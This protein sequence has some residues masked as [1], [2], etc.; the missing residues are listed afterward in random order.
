MTGFQTNLMTG[1]AQL[2]AAASVGTWNP[3]GA[4]QATDTAIV[5]R[6]LPETPDAIIA[7]TTYPVTSDPSLSESVVGLQVLTRTG[8]QDPRTTDDLADSIFDQLQGLHDVTL[9][10][11]VHLVQCLHQGGGAL[12]DDDLHRWARSDNYYITAHR[13]SPN[14]T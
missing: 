10:T 9:A 1:V 7:L 13:P 3:S 6:T 2:L 5:L 8:G 11:G 14:R 4:Y 12:P